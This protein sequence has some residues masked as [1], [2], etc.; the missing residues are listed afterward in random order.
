MAAGL[1]E[2]G[3]REVEPRKRQARKGLFQ[4][5]Q[6]APGAAGDVEKRE[7]ALV[8]AAQKLGD[9]H[10]ALSAHGVCRSGEQDLDLSIVETGRLIG[11]ISAG[12][13]VKVLQEV[14]REFAREAG[15][16]DF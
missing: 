10:D 16:V 7:I 3:L 5:T 15:I 1:I 12:L 2:I 8:A 11:Q 13:I 14:V 4:E 9:R 6:K